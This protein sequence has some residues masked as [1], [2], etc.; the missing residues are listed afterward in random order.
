MSIINIIMII[1]LSKSR[2]VETFGRRNVDVAQRDK[3]H[4]DIILFQQTVKSLHT[5]LRDMCVSEAS[6]FPFSTS[7]LIFQESCLLLFPLSSCFLLFSFY[8]QFNLFSFSL[9]NVVSPLFTECSTELAINKQ[10]NIIERVF[11]HLESQRRC[12][13]LSLC[14]RKPYRHS[15]A[16]RHADFA[17][18]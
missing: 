5:Y 1:W 6:M 17:C 7:S 9:Q 11:T 14:T 18:F 12:T 8:S 16:S 13:A 3:L 2:T 10:T 4:L 15:W